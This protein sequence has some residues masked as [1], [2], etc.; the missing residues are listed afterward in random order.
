M[1]LKGF[2]F[3]YHIVPL[4]FVQS[5]EWLKLKI[6]ELQPELTKLGASAK[7]A[8]ELSNAHDQVL[9]RLQVKLNILDSSASIYKSKS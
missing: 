5:G 2:Q 3:C 9:L 1:L 4:S 7:E 6:L 8:T